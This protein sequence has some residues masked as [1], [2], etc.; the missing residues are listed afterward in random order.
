M[1]PS[2]FFIFLINTESSVIVNG[3]IINGIV[4][5]KIKVNENKSASIVEFVQQNALFSFNTSGG[6]LTRIFSFADETNDDARTR[7]NASNIKVLSMD[8][9]GSTYFIVYGYMNRG[10]HEGTTGITLYYYDAV[11]NTIE[12]QLFIPYTKSF[13]ILDTDLEQ[14]SF[15]NSRGRLYLFVDGALYSITIESKE[16][17]IIASDLDE[18]R[19]VSSN[20]NSV[21]AWQEGESITDYTSIQYY[22]LDSLAPISLSGD[23]GNII[24]FCCVLASLPSNHTIIL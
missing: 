23:P 17:K 16:A 8:E 24:I 10:V 22:A 21:I 7:Y 12:E 14:L 19:F 6:Q 4:N 9:N 18:N 2:I 5:E 13:E 3:K 1:L 15:I 11:V 20:D